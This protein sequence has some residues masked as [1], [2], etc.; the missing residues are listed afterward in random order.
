MT[1][2]LIAA[3]EEVQTATLA[4][5]STLTDADIYAEMGKAVQYGQK[6]VV[7]DPQTNIRFGATVYVGKKGHSLVAD[8]QTW[9]LDFWQQIEQLF[10][11]RTI[12]PQ[13]PSTSRMTIEQEPGT[14]VIYVDGSYIKHQDDHAAIGWAFEVWR[15]ALRSM[16]W[17]A[18]SQ[19]RT[20]L[21]FGTLRANV[22]P[23]KKRSTGVMSIAAR[24]LRSG[25]ITWA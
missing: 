14:T 24:P 1:P 25:S 10:K 9:P 6:I 8:G 7:L 4:F 12:L 3:A 16:G 11:G 21:R 17:R 13:A 2:A 20:H 18:A 19:T 5:I 23:S 15:E 22:M